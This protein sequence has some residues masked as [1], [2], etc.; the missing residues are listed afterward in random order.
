M[1]VQRATRGKTLHFRFGASV[2]RVV[3]LDVADA[4]FERD[5]VALR[6]YW[7]PRLDLLF[8]ELRKAPSILRITYVADLESRALVKRRMRAL[9]RSL[10]RQWR[11]G[12]PA[13]ALPIEQEVLWR[14]GRPVAEDKRLP[15][16]KEAP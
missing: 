11:D 14:T 12:S 5:G 4:V 10:R 3:G 16:R 15:N 2:H 8:D 6:P 1:Q 7:Q 13:G 9:T